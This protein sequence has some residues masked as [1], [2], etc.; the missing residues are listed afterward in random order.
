MAKF[1]LILFLLMVLCILGGGIYLMNADIP[2]PT[3]RVEKPLADD[4]FPK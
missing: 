3:E 4:M 2:A 1:W